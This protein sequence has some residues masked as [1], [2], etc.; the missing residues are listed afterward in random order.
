MVARNPQEERGQ[1]VVC[2]NVYVCASSTCPFVHSQGLFPTAYVSVIDPSNVCVA[3]GDLEAQS[4]T[5]LTLKKGLAFVSF[6]W[7][8]TRYA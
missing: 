1:T 4:E 7:Q 2:Y 8:V 3:N 5:E 6:G